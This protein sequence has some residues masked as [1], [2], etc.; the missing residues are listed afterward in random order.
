MLVETLGDIPES[1]RD[2]AVKAWKEQGKK[3]VGFLC[4][5]VP[6]EILYAADILP[7]RVRA[8]GCKRTA[9]ADLWMSNFTC[10]FARSCL[11]FALD[12]SYDFLD[13]VI[14]LDSCAMIHKLHDNWR[15][16]GHLSFSHFLTVPHKNG[17]PAVLWYRAELEA[18]KRAVG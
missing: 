7:Y 4:A 8:T 11:E 1:L 16:A 14:G 10:S 6:E 5:Y 17:E 9:R 13:G 3:I 18:M 2:E 12:G 15:L